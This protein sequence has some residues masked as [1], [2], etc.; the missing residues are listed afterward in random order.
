M[1]TAL[2]IE[3]HDTGFFR[4][5]HRNRIR[6]EYRYCDAAAVK[7]VTYEHYRG[8]V[9]WSVI[10]R[11]VKAQRNRLLCPEELELPVQSGYKRYVSNELSRRMCENAALFLLRAADCRG[12]KVV[13]IDDTGDSVGLCEYL[14][15]FCDPVYVVTSAT[16]IYAAQAEYLL[17]DRGAA[18]RI[19][20]STDCLSDADLVV[21]PLKLSKTLP[22]PSYSLIL[23]SERPSARQNTTAIFEYFFDLPSKYRDLCPSGLDE[24]YFASALFARTGARELGGELFTRCGDGVTLHTRGSLTAMFKKRMNSRISA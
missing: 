13:L 12:V 4:M 20:G 6:A 11:Y 2:Q 21:A 16:D 18:L 15:D 5:L 9:N 7:C 17:N 10:D 19:C 24:M 14:T 3:R 23:T 8:K 1:L 22:C